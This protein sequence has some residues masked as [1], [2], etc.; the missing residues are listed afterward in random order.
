LI[1]A[2][3]PISRYSPFTTQVFLVHLL[4]MSYERLQEQA[5]GETLWSLPELPTVAELGG[6]HVTDDPQEVLTALRAGI[7]LDRGIDISPSDDLQ[8]SGLYF[9]EHPQLW[10]GR[11]TNKWR[12]AEHLTAEQRGAIAQA[13]QQ[14][15]RFAET[16]YL[17][18]SERARAVKWLERF[19][20]SGN[21]VYLQF[22][23]EQPYNFPSWKP[24]FLSQFGVINNEVPHV[25]PVK[26]AGS[27][28]D[29]SSA[30]ISPKL[31]VALKQSGHDGAF[32]NGSIAFLPQAVV[33]N[34]RAIVQFGDYIPNP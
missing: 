5:R 6:Y 3:L 19:T 29:V 11:S 20:E 21:A 31:I 26:V 2:E 15:S 24:G 9:S 4:F 27:F 16:W 17:T 18:D 32:I 22:L 25:L 23:A 14:D 12:F 33:W 34:N 10:V 7:P 8:A 28:A 30:R 1:V 13:M